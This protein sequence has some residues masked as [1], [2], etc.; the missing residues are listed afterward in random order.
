VHWLLVLT[1]MGLIIGS[2]NQYGI[3]VPVQAAAPAA[4]PAK[5]EPAKTGG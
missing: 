2:F 3:G 1:A 5:A 4:A